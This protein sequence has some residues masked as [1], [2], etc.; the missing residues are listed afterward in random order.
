MFRSALI[1]FVLAAG[2]LPA[3]MMTG[4]FTTSVYGFE[5]RD[6]ALANVLYLRAYEQVYFSAATEDYS[7]LMNA[8]VSNDFGTALDT[9]PELRVSSFLMKIKN[10]GG[11]ADV[12]AGRQFV[13][14]GVGYGLIDGVSAT[15]RL[16]DNLV[17]IT[18]YGGT[19]VNH[20]RD[21]GKSY[22][23]TN[24]LFGGQI[25]VAPME[26]GLIGFSYMNKRRE[27]K[28][29]TTLR[30]DSLF[31]PTLVVINSLPYEEELLSADAEYQH[32]RTFTVQAKGDF[33]LLTDEIAKIQ[34][35]VRVGVND[36][37]NVTAEYIFREPRLAYNSIFSVF[38][39]NSTQEIEGGVEYR[40][41]TQSSFYA[42]FATVSYSDESSGRLVLGGSYDFVSAVITQNFGY[43]GELSG[44][45]VQAVY[46]MMERTLTPMVGFGY[47]TYKHAPADAAN[48]V[49]NGTAGV[50]YRPVKT[51]SVDTQVQWMSNPQYSSD[52]RLFLRLHYWFT[53]SLGWL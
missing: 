15:A 16:F 36:Q 23:G 33:D 46:P 19:N 39:V 47:A 53:E 24:G 13:F 28:P 18:G 21:I 38:T 11:L 29:Y 8:M 7:F 50:V 3:Q 42:R 48:D 51:F 6:T 41:T 12:S 5:G 44:I 1:M 27:R 40:P 45:S 14:A 43:A 30:L 32:G 4:R 10:I 49:L 2:S 52:L 9:D 17:G 31:Q 20:T 34:S 26:V 22:I 37:I 25:T 35:F